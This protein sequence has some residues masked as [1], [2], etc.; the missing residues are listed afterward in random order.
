MGGSYS[1]I[2]M[3]EAFSAQFNFYGDVEAAHIVMKVFKHIVII[4]VELAF[5][6]PNRDFNKFFADQNTEMGRYISNIFDKMSYILCDPL[7]LLP[8]FYPN[9]ITKVYKVYG[10]VC[11]EGARTRGF[12]AINWLPSKNTNQFE[13]NLQIVL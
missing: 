1:G 4:P 11:R 7:I 3:N 12:L 13:P 6:Y 10:E 8:I 9:F 5:Q 2:G